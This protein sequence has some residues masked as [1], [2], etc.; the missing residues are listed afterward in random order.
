MLNEYYTL[1]GWD[2]ETGLRRETLM[3]LGLPEVVEK[4][5]EWVR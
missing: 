1:P 5:G 3:D 4:L 2:P